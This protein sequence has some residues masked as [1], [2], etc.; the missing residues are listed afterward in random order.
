MRRKG[1]G[2]GS[3]F[4][5]RVCV[6][7]SEWWTGGER[8][9]VFWRTSMSGGRATVRKRKGK[10]THGQYGD[11][12]AIDP[13]GQPFLDCFAI[14]VKRGYPTATVHDLLDTKKPIYQKWIEQAEASREASGAEWWMIVHQRDRRETIITMPSSW[15]RLLDE[16]PDCRLINVETGNGEEIECISLSGFLK[17]VRPDTLRN[18]SMLRKHNER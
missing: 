5:R 8:S 13:I 4:E 18:L 3:S 15:H 16:W 9:D 2:K 1:K 17:Y 12:C 11:I 6:L 10:S 7:L 14:E